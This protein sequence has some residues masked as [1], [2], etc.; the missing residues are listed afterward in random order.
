[1]AADQQTLEQM[2]H[3]LEQALQK[4]NPKGQPHSGQPNEADEAMAQLQDMLQSPAMRAARDMLG[5]M[6]R[7]QSAQARRPGQQ[8]RNQAPTPSQSQA[9]QTGDNPMAPSTELASLPLSTQQ[10]IL[11]L[12]PR[13]REELLQGMREQGPDGY[14]PFIEDYF[15]RLTES[16]NP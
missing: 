13:V 1:M 9:S 8:G 7:A 3:G 10:A 6:R 11:K 4:S 15:K 5:R 16:K 2:L 12:P 14:G